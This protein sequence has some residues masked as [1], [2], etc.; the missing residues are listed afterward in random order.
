MLIEQ[1]LQDSN[2]IILEFI[3]EI[4]L[5]NFIIYIEKTH[6]KLLFKTSRAGSRR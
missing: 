4:L 2:G 6:G 5:L 3:N 1:I